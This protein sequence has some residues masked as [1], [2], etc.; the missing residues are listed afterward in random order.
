VGAL[1][2]R[3]RYG[4]LDFDAVPLLGE[5]AIS[6]VIEA[7]PVFFGQGWL[8][9]AATLVW[10]AGVAALVY[11]VLASAS[12]HDDLGVYS[13]AE[14]PSNTPTVQPEAPEAAVS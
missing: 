9:V 6:Y 12:A 2:V 8:Q 11:A 3:L 14:Q 1:L 4:A 7:P 10:P 13:A 5:R